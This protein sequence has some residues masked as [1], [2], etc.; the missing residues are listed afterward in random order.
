MK[1]FLYTVVAFLTAFTAC[2]P[3]PDSALKYHNELA[4]WQKK[5]FSAEDSL[6]HFINQAMERSVTD[7]GS[8]ALKDEVYKP[9]AN[10]DI[11]RCYNKLLAQ[12]EESGNGINAM[13]DFHKDLSLKNAATDVINAYK[14]VCNKEYP[15]IIAITEINPAAYTYEDDNRF[16][17]LSQDIDTQIQQK[18]SL[19]IKTLKEFAKIYNFD[20]PSDTSGHSKN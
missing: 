5:V 14:K 1:L 13:K 6:I 16:L 2:R 10:P 17:E 18:I 12:V 11:R 4:G 8:M 15:E 19:Y 3:S 9:G 20:L 7:S